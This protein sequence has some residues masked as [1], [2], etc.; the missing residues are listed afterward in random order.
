MPKSAVSAEERVLNY[1]EQ[2]NLETAQ[3]VFN[4]VKSRLRARTPQADAPAPKRRG[5]ARK[6]VQGEESQAG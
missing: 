2:A 3:V 6:K 1:F 4:L 5:P